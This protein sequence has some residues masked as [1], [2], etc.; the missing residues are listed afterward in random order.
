MVTQKV[1]TRINYMSIS[2]LVY[3]CDYHIYNATGLQLSEKSY[4]VQEKLGMQRADT[5]SLAY[6][7]QT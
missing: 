7:V 2:A 6:E 4:S 1:H 5:Q 3:I